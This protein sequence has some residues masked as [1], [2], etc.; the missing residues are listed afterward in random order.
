MSESLFCDHPCRDAWRADRRAGVVYGQ[1]EL[2]T[3][4]RRRTMPHA[5]AMR[6][7]G[8]CVYCRA[9]LRRAA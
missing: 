6:I 3:G 8:Q 2:V 9:P 1:V 7:L 5:Q 4:A